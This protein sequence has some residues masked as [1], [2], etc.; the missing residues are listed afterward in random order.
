M[1]TDKQVDQGRENI[2]LAVS[3]AANLGHQSVTNETWSV[4]LRKQKS[5]TGKP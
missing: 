3:N 5:K 1:D 2:S 4:G